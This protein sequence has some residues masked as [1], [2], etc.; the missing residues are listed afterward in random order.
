MNIHV[1]KEL[2]ENEIIPSYNEINKEGFVM[3]S[4]YYYGVNEKC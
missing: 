1:V 4:L 2:V 3:K